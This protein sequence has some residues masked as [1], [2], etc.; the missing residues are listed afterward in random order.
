MTHHLIA[1]L[2]VLALSTA[3]R[4]QT[5]VPRVMGGSGVNVD[6]SINVTGSGWVSWWCPS[7]KGPQLRLLAS[8]GLTDTIKGVRCF[9]AASTGPTKAIES[10]APADIG[11]PALKAVWQS[12]WQRIQATKPK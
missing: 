10:C 3:A 4:A 2:L 6:L 12:D 1:S 11:S 7:T 9:M 5:C 8:P